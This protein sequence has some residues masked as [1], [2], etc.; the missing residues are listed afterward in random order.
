MPV[1]PAAPSQL[2]DSSQEGVCE[3]G[4]PSSSSLDNGHPSVAVSSV[5][6]TDGPGKKKRRKVVSFA[7]DPPVSYDSF[8]GVS[9]R[10]SPSRP[11]ME[12]RN[13]RSSARRRNAREKELEESAMEVSFTHLSSPSP[14]PSPSLGSMAPRPDEVE[15]GSY[16]SLPGSSQTREKLSD[17]ESVSSSVSSVAS[18]SSLSIA[19]EG[20]A[21]VLPKRRG[22]GRPRGSRNART[23]SPLVR[24]QKVQEQKKVSAPAEVIVIESEEEMEPRKLRS[25]SEEGV[26]STKLKNP[27]EEGG[28]PANGVEEMVDVRRLRS[29]EDVQ[30]TGQDKKQ[31]NEVIPRQGVARG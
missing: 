26:E 11:G 30:P 5:T 18:N 7:P 29:W 23:R 10:E 22:P 21:P 27:V 24:E 4:S 20:V 15:A 17:D 28:K 3:A 1:V 16:L 13:T 2:L 31:K 12:R 25:S 14:S 19:G 9:R 6:S 8:G